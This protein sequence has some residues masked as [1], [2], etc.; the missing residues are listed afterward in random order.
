MQEARLEQARKIFQ[1]AQQCDTG[2]RSAYLDEACAGDPELRNTV[3]LMMVSQLDTMAQFRSAPEQLKSDRIGPYTMIR[4]LGQGGMGAVY[5]ADNPNSDLY[6]HVA[7]KVI[8]RGMDSEEVLQRFQKEHQILAALDHPNIASLIDA[9]T[10][11]DGLPYFL[12]EYISG[13]PIDSYCD[14]RKL[15]VE[16]R[17]KLFRVV[18]SAVEYAHKKLVVHRDLKPANILVTS[19]GV[20]KLLDFGIAKLLDPAEGVAT[21]GLTA[22]GLRVM[23]PDY[24]SPEQVRGEPITVSSDIYAL[25]VVLYQLLSG[26]RPYLL[27]QFNPL[28]MVRVVCETEP[29]KPSSVASSKELQNSLKGNLDNIVLMALQ[30][31]PALRYSNVQ[32]FSE[33]IRRHLEGTYVAARTAM[34]RYRVKQFVRKRAKLL[35]V[36]ALIAGILASFVLFR[37]SFK[38]IAPTNQIRSVAVLPFQ[39]VSSMKRD[40]YLEQGITDALITRL[41]GLKNVLV[42]RGGTPDQYAKL[43]R[44]AI[45]IGRKL[46][47]E[48]VLE[49]NIQ[50][51]ESQ[52]HVMARLIRI[53]DEQVLWSGSYDAP[54]SAILALEELI[55]QEAAKA[56]T[57]LSNE[58]KKMLVERETTNVAAYQSYLR[59][60]Y[61]WNQRTTEGYEKALQHFQEAIHEDPRFAL[62]YVG[63]ANA[64][65]FLA[66]YTLPRPEAMSKARAYLQKAIAINPDLA[67]A[68][69]ALALIKMNYDWDW[70]GAE[71]E[72]LSAIALN[73]DYPTAHHWYGEF[74][75]LMGRSD[76]GIRE[77]KRALELDPLSLI[78]NTDLARGLLFARKYDQGIAQLKK[79]LEMDPGYVKARIWLGRGY[80]YKGMYKEAISEFQSLVARDQSLEALAELG[81]TYGMAGKRAEAKK[82]LAQ[83]MEES[84]HQSVDPGLFTTVY[85]G[86]G[87]AN[88]TFYWL[89]KQYAERSVGLIALKSNPHRP[90]LIFSDP[91]FPD[92]MR[93]I[94]F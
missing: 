71:K 20:P 52:L 33:D 32:E 15:E 85:V 39:P 87:D 88:K 3:E 73:P 35:L 27:N 16:D 61:S 42:R 75:T 65:S 31:Y 77:V 68:H 21:T 92:L 91:R 84:K 38:S 18:C 24:A 22:T 9:G 49:G 7:I 60:M 94:G 90:P 80:R 72:Y 2:A 11:S 46:N 12:M 1:H 8:R 69:N 78:I 83:L 93:R 82:I 28:E 81:L 57:T 5:L 55:C 14:N 59:G 43:K 17:L 64:Y 40:E 26:Q 47:V 51:S 10:T 58:E 37:S 50:Q 53:S 56:L 66:E 45:G 48:A 74:L 54:F 86:L 6:R 44:D 62:A 79:T 19:Q 41:S 34:A 29:K 70:A 13:E 25:G 23:T 63:T 76:Q 89:E 67:E 4:K 30:K 36:F